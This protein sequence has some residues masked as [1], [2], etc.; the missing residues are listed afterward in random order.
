MIRG[1]EHIALSV[2]NLERSISFYTET[3]PLRLERIIDCPPEMR[4][5]DVARMP[6]C[7]ARIAHLLSERV[8]LELF[9]YHD[10]DGRP[11]SPDRRQADCGYIHIGFASDD[12]PTDC[13]RLK[14]RGVE[15]LS[16]PLEFRPGVW[17]VYFYGPDGEVC[18]LRQT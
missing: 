7:R 6:G 17:I 13:E 1:L 2:S 10:P 15:F 18:E 12:V 9:E 4:L 16:D 11:I 14:K 8:M 5:G 3:L